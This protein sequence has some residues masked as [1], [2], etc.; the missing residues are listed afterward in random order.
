MIENNNFELDAHKEALTEICFDLFERDRN[1]NLF[2]RFKADKN[3]KRRK[4][5]DVSRKVSKDLI[6]RN[7][8]KKEHNYKMPAA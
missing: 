3:K 8:L 1:E 4:K 6:R 5:L 7:N 2:D